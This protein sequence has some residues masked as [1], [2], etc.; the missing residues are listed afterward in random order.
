VNG[1]EG[2]MKAEDFKERCSDLFD[3][4]DGGEFKDPENGLE[5]IKLNNFFRHLLPDDFKAFSAYLREKNDKIGD[6]HVEDFFEMFWPKLMQYSFAVGFAFGNLIE[7]T[8]P[9]I[10]NDLDVIKK[11]IMEK[12]LLP[13]LPRGQKGGRHEKD[14]TRKSI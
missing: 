9:T 6:E 14:R 10:L 2:T 4:F 1:K 8:D 5:D 7:P 13:Y 3:F 12:Q 11:E